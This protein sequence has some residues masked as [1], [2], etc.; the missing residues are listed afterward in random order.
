MYESLYW[1][2]VKK[3]LAC[4]PHVTD[5]LVYFSSYCVPYINIS[6]LLDSSQQ[7]RVLAPSDC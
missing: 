4:K 5:R 2:D 3:N 6:T 7:I 1:G